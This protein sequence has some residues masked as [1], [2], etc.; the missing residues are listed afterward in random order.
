[1]Y[2]DAKLIILIDYIILQRNLSKSIFLIIFLM[3]LHKYI[4]NNE[5]YIKQ[6]F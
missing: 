5:L 4:K 6:F 1:M 3:K 2:S